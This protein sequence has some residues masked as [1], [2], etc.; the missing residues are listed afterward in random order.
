M[1]L[2]PLHPLPSQQQ[3]LAL[4]YAAYPMPSNAFGAP[5]APS[6]AAASYCSAAAAP[7]FLSDASAAAA[8]PPWNAWQAPLPPPLV[9][10]PAP[11]P[12]A[13]SAAAPAAVDVVLIHEATMDDARGGDAAAKRHSTVGGALALAERLRAALA[14]ACAS[15]GGAATAVAPARLA[16]AG[17]VLTHFSQRYPRLPLAAAAACAA[18]AAAAGCAAPGAAVGGAPTA[19]A[20][21]SHASERAL[22]AFDAMRLP[23]RPAPPLL[24]GGGACAPPATAGAFPAA[25]CWPAFDSAPAITARI[26]AALEGGSGAGGMSSCGGGRAAAHEAEAY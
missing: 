4:P 12:T 16:L 3:L 23:I 19:L 21:P 11:P 24:L 26:Y 7:G 17:V 13:L 10:A 14:A 25:T 15:E 8:L 18:A 1:L 5:V 2:G 6:T 20:Q 9:V 22:F